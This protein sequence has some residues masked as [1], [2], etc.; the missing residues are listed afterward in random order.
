MCEHKSTDL[1][2]TEFF[3]SNYRTQDRI[4]KEVWEPLTVTMPT[5]K[6]ENS[7]ILEIDDI[8]KTCK[9]LTI[10]RHS[11]TLQEN[12]VLSTCND[13]FDFF[14]ERTLMVLCISGKFSY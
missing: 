11:P 4:V 14:I 7:E 10:P 13:K 6:M 9:N 5:G 2:S 3:L 8:C 1:H 12:D